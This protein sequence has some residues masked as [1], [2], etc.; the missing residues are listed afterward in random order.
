MP[1]VHGCTYS[2]HRLFYAAMQTSRW[3][4]GVW[5]GISLSLSACLS[6][7][8]DADAAPPRV[9]QLDVVQVSTITTVQASSG[10]FLSP[11]PEQNVPSYVERGVA[12]SALAAAQDERAKVDLALLFRTGNASFGSADL[13]AELT[14]S[15]ERSS[16]Q[17]Y[18]PRVS[19]SNPTLDW[20]LQVSAAATTE[21]GS[22]VS[23]EWR[24]W[25]GFRGLSVRASAQG[26]SAPVATL[27]FEILGRR[28]PLLLS[29]KLDNLT[30]T[31]RSDR[32]IAR[33]LLI[34]CHP[35]GVGVTAIDQ[36]GPGD[37]ALTALGP[38]E[39]PQDVLLDIAQADL[40]AFFASLVGDELGA[41]MAQAKS[42]PFLETEGLRLITLL[43]EDQE[44][45]Q[46][47]FSSPVVQQQHVVVSH[48]EVLLP[49][50]EARVLSVVADP[51]IG[52]EQVTTALGRFTQGKL[53]FALKNGDAAVSER[54]ATLLNELRNR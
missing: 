17:H 23:E 28:S 47:S 13:P 25:Q 2:M 24:G 20:P 3:L 21:L 15:A 27:D 10:L 46:V 1:E 40:S 16:V 18:F 35:G 6:G 26:P 14:T 41:A 9:S 30:V 37:H 42:I 50:E 11:T 4:V 5:G 48:S 36:L 33:G 43:D 19:D 12:D 52:A 49:D 54:S 31:N 7:C 22:D 29:G 38:K 39:H 51:S 34:Y 32:T 44:P 45:A 8:D 53:E